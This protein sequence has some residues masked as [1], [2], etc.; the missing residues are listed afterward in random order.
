[1]RTI[2]GIVAICQLVFVTNVFGANLEP[3]IGGYAASTI[4]D[5]PN[6][7]PYKDL[8]I[9]I[10]KPGNSLGVES[11]QR[12]INTLVAADKAG[13]RFVQPAQTGVMDFPKQ[14][15]A[16]ITTK[17]RVG[18]PMCQYYK[19][20]IFEVASARYQE[21]DKIHRIDKLNQSA[22]KQACDK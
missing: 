22:K 9:E 3:L 20:R 4:K 8:I 5:T 7:K 17:Y 15:A 1:M 13:C 6:C 21:Y 19:T 16:A 14:Y 18:E 2:F 12:R 10:E 11:I